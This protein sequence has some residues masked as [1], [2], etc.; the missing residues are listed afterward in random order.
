MVKDAEKFKDQD[1][2]LRK[3]IEAKNNLESYVNNVKNAL[4]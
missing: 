3:K 4:N 1:E 2:I